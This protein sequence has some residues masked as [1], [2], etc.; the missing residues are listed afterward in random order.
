M[1]Y[2]EYAKRRAH[3]CYNR[4]GKRRGCCSSLGFSFVHGLV[5][6][7][8]KAQVLR[9]RRIRFRMRWILDSAA[10]RCM[11]V[12]TDWKVIARPK[13]IASVSGQ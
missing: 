8:Q 12:K 6:L 10:P 2:D 1:T 4:E 13:F 7:I 5:H 11:T 9:S 3:S